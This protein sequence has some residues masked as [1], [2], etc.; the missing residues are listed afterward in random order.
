MVWQGAGEY[1][2]VVLARC[3]FLRR[4]GSVEALRSAF[5]TGQEKVSAVDAKFCDPQLRLPAYQ[6]HCELQMGS[7][8]EAA[9]AVW[10]EA[11]KA[12][13]GTD[14]AHSV[15]EINRSARARARVCVCVCV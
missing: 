5:K 4:Q 12:E 2:E 14:V 1:L 11:L 6:A 8:V 10:E 7:G 15:V 3:D 9:R 13:T